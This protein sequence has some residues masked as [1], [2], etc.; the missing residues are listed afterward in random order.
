MLSPI[1]SSLK[2]GYS[3]L[4]QADLSVHMYVAYGVDE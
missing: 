3:G 2:G 4:L 1:V